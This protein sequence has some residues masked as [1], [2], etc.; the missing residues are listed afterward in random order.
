MYLKVTFE[1]HNK[2]PSLMANVTLFSQII[3]KLD[4][5]KF[6]KLVKEHQSDKHQ[7]GYTSWTHLVSMLFCQF[8]KSQSVR[9]ISNGLRS[10]TGNLNHLGIDKAPSKSTISYQNKHRNWELF[11]SYYYNLLGSLGQQVG[12][13]QVKFKIKSKIFLLDSTTISLC[14]SL[15]DWAKYKTAKGAVKMHTLLDFDGNLPAYVNITDGKTADNKGAYDIPLLKGSVIVADRFYNDFSLL[16]IWDS[17]GVYFVIRHKE[18]IQYTVIKENELP[19]NRHQHILKDEIIELKNTV[20]SNKYPN[21]IR[22]VS[23]WDDLNEQVIELITNQMTWTANT[24]GELYKS[25]WN[26]EIFFRDIKQ[27][28]HIKS[29][30][31]TSKNAVMIQIWTALITILVLKALKAMAKFGWHLSNLVAFIRLNLF[32]KIDL[33]T[34]IDNPFEEYK[35]PLEKNI[36]GVLF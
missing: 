15:F 10:A 1:L 32:V 9:D 36:Q 28:L 16:N 20:S 5:T 26:V 11:R 33:Q 29:F 8:A 21:K 14:L 12:F 18:N 6:S 13:K 30:I 7:K 17:K 22:R 2:T 31:G 19:E 35:E 23:V 27:L 34:W 3:G 4:R 24:I 25:R